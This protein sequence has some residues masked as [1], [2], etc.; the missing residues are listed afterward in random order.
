[1]QDVSERT[2]QPIVEREPS[3]RRLPPCGDSL[4]IAAATSQADKA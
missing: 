4:V 3:V 1:M 2:D